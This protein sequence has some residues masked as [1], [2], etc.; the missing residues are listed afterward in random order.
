[1]LTSEI[2][3][4]FELY[5]DDTT[6]LSAS[7]ELA[8]AN[9]VCREIC[10]EKPWEF[11]KKSGTGS[12]STSLPYINLPADF[13]YM[14]ENNQSSDSSVMN[15]NNGAAKVVF[16]G[17]TYTPYQVV[18]WSDRRTYLNTNGYCYVDIVNS[19]LYFTAQPTIAD[20]YE[21]DYIFNPVDLTT[22]T[23]PVFPARFHEMVYHGM[24]VQDEITQKYPKANSYAAENKAKYNDYMAQMSSWNARL[25][26]NN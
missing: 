7:Q 10:N 2:F 21:F 24:A 14:I 3:T 20:T 18:N 16:V 15:D 9:K 22:G 11:L 23:S 19:R 17:S 13:A 26:L 12:L 4:A 8:L 5:V 6:E 1:M 25:G